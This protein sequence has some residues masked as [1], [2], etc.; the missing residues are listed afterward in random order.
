MSRLVHR[1]GIE[2]PDHAIKE[3]Y[4]ARVSQFLERVDKTRWYQNITIPGRSEVDVLDKLFAWGDRTWNEHISLSNQLSEANRRVQRLESNLSNARGKIHHLEAELSTAQEKVFR[5]GTEKK[6][7]EIEHVENLSKVEAEQERIKMQHIREMT[8]LKGT[9]NSLLQREQHV[10]EQEKRKLV[11]E[12]LVNQ[13]DNSGWTDEKLKFSFRK[14]QNLISTLVSSRSNIG[15]R[16]SPNCQIGSGLDPTGFLGRATTS[17]T[18]FLLQS[19]IWNIL[20]ENF[21]LAPFGFGILGPGEP[22]TQLIGMFLSWAQLLGRLTDRSMFSLGLI[23]L[24]LTDNRPIQLSS[25]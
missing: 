13:D 1:K 9:H 20:Y 18:H 10:R 25:I 7:M 19:R 21:F 24:L 22:Q 15:F 8:S 11:G 16:L 3:R 5:L 17:K 23:E 14:L 12:L 6:H 4:D 2:V